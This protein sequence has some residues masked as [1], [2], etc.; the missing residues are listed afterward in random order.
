MQHRESAATAM[1]AESD[2]RL[3]VYMSREGEIQP[4]AESP[5]RLSKLG[6]KEHPSLVLALRT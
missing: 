2:Y 6:I 3:L 1:L 4:C 5:K